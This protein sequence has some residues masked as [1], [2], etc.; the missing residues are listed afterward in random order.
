M[1]REF[2]D[3]V[4]VEGL[5]PAERERLERVH[6]LLVAAGPPPELTAAIEQAPA[7]VIQ[8]PVWRRRPLVA[9]L[10]AAVAVAGA[11]FGGGYV[12]GNDN[13]GIKAAQVMSL[14]GQP[15]ELASLRIGTPDAVGNSPMI[16][17]VTGLPQLEHGYYELYTW[18]NGKPSYA[19]GGFK[20]LNGTTSV[21]L[22]VP[23]ELKPGTKLVVTVIRGGE[24]KPGRVVM[25]SV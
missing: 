12:V 15:N 8:F 18:R 10:A 16:L 14:Q 21:H 19:C 13:G 25:R 9:A 22:T 11:A 5:T 23:Y 24:D 4:D 3:W 2:N 7:Q 1:T 20:M 17:T 6:A